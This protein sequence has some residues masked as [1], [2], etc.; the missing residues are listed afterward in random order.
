M[1]FAEARGQRAPVNS[2]DATT[3]PA[4]AQDVAPFG[5]VRE[6]DLVRVAGWGRIT[7][8]LRREAENSPGGIS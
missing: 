6:S 1:P 3:A 5:K 7:S 2:V 8:R 4:L